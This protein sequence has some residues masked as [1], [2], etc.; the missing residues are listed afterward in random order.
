MDSVLYAIAPE[1]DFTLYNPQT[2]YLI[3]ALTERFKELERI[4]GFTET[5]IFHLDCLAENLS[6]SLSIIEVAECLYKN[7]QLKWGWKDL[8]PVVLA[9]CLYPFHADSY[10]HSVRM[11]EIVKFLQEGHKQRGFANFPDFGNKDFA[12]I[13]RNLMMAEDDWACLLAAAYHHDGGKM[14][15]KKG[16]WDKPGKFTPKEK[17]CRKVHPGMFFPIG[18]MFGVPLKVTALAIAHHYLNLG[19]PNNGLIKCFQDIIFEPKF[20]V[21]L[22]MLTTLD[23]YD[24]MRGPREY[25][26][27]LFSHDQ[28]MENLPYEL[29]Q[30]GTDFVPL[31]EL[32]NSSAIGQQLYPH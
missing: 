10:L 14:G 2:Q 3:L 31:V 20:K 4:R 8:L 16:F 19:Y 1:R 24:G 6:Q 30:M 5:E 23:C 22:I 25:R 27:D 12:E 29:G 17:E 11:A 21:I 15:L 13:T 32:V 28:V 26:V 7:Q 18:E 9:D